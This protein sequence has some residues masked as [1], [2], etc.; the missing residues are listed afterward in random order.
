MSSGSLPDSSGRKTV[1]VNLWRFITRIF[2][3]CVS[4]W[5]FLTAWVNI[6]LRNYESP[7]W[8]VGEARSGTTWLMELLGSDGKRR[9]LFEPFH[10]KFNHTLKLTPLHNYVPTDHDEMDFR[11]FCANVFQ[12]KLFNGRVDA[13]RNYRLFHSGLVIKDVYA[14]LLLPYMSK[15]FDKVRKILILRNPI[16]VA[17]S[18]QKRP[19]GHWINNPVDFLTDDALVKDH[20]EP[21]ADMIRS[22]EDDYFQK[23]VMIWCVVHYVPLRVL[24]PNL[25]HV[26]LY[27][28][29]FADPIKELLR[30]NRFLGENVVPVDD[31]ILNVVDVPSRMTERSRQFFSSQKNLSFRPGIENATLRS[32]A[33][34]MRA[35]GMEG[36]YGDRFDTPNSEDVLRFLREAHASSS[37]SQASFREEKRLS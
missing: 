32:C 30:I 33:R 28:E 31:R 20:L 26:V 3:S 23:Q 11:D 21:F 27:E 7:V 34:I 15:N 10:P 25:L 1:M 6:L 9:V 29:L 37:D 4:A 5:T 14:N 18:K 2:G 12:G 22:L 19:M 24:G 13:Y 16:A 17:L 8:V 35:F 36:F